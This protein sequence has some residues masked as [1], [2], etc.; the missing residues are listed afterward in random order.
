MEIAL[1][2]RN[3]VGDGS[4]GSEE[5]GEFAE[6]MSRTECTIDGLAS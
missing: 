1:I 5:L 2:E 4:L 3:P 6:E